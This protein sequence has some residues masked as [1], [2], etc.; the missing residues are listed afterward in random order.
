M[1]LVY[2]LLHP[3]GLSSY[4]HAV[5]IRIRSLASSFA[6]RARIVAIRVRSLASSIASRA[7]IVAIRVRSLALSFGSRARIVGIRIRSLAYR[8]FIL[9]LVRERGRVRRR[10]A[11]RSSDHPREKPLYS[12]R[13]RFERE[14]SKFLHH[15]LP[16]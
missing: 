8:L 15:K 12:R 2:R 6:S 3:P 1:N 7:R 16:R 13:F 14:A 9:P 5:E 11:T 4:A 10:P